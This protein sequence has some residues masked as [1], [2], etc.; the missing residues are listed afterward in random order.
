MKNNKFYKI[1]S[2]F[3]LI[4][5]LSACSEDFLQVEPIGKLAESDFYETDQDA[6]MALIATYDILQWANARD[7]NSAYFVKTLPSDESNT[8]GGDAGDQPPYQ[9]LNTYTYSSGNPTIAATYQ[10][11]YYGIF[12]ANKVI[13]EIDPINDFRKDIIA[14]AKCLRA[15]YY[16]ELVSMFGRV[17]LILTEL[18]PSEYKQPNAE[19]STIYAQ[20]E[21]DLSDAIAELPLKSEYA[22]EDKFRVSKGTA[23]ALLGKAY[24]FQEKWQQAADVLSDVI[25]S[26]EFDLE[27]EF[28]KLF[29]EETEFGIESLF[30]VSYINTEGYDWGTFQWGGNRSM[31]NNIHWQLMGPRGDFFNAGESSLVGGWGFNYPT[32]RIYQ[33]YVDAGDVIRRNATVMSQEELEAMGG[34]W[35]NESAWGYEG[36]FRV[37]Y[38]TILS[39]TNTDAVAELNYGT[40]LRLLR[41]ADV[42]LMAAEAN[43]RAGDEDQARIELNKVRERA[44]LDDVTTSGADLFTAI[45]T[46]R[47]LELAFE[48]VRF[49]DLIRWDLGPSVLGT[50]GFQ[51]GKHELYPIPLE[52]INNND[53]LEQNPGW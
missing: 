27:P 45:V 47:N 3:V 13:N 53:L 7:W 41:F 43:Y 20:I 48:G 29:L 44:G 32:E 22:F 1:L 4:I 19:V 16:F 49:L 21:A 34:S 39:E 36:Y 37:K 26:N 15:Y 11:N 12:R 28:D 50:D 9:E 18:A 38:G 35:T 52:E 17:P 23:Q 25:E 40:N 8:G 33:A 30:E 46:E 24:L 6:M 5:M 51:S 42:L 10:S 31:E 14:E 2:V